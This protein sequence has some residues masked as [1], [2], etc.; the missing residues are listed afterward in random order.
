MPLP[1]HSLF[2]L[3]QHS[4]CSNRQCLRPSA[5]RRPFP[6]PPSPPGS[7]RSFPHGARGMSHL[8]HV[9]P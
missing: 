1:W 5:H 8:R 4:S 2:L 7:S 6:P 9:A 3:G